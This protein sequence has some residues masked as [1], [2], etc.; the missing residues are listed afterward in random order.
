MV[1]DLPLN[2]IT[3]R[4]YEKPYDSSKRALVKKV[5]LSLGLLQ[6]GDSRDVVVDILMVLDES[7]IKRAEM[8]SFEIIDRVKEIRKSHSLEEK[9]IAESNVRRQ[10]KRLRDLM[11]VDKKNNNYRLSEFEPLSEIFERKI[12]GF[13]IPQT[14]DRIKEYLRRLDA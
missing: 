2:E 14:L 6:P 5:C 1:R 12:E 3:L 7:R 10:L 11:I 9:G 4:K 8:N 13:L